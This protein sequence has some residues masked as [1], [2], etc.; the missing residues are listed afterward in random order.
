MEV[1]QMRK[2]ERFIQEE[3]RVLKEELAHMF[4]RLIVLHYKYYKNNEADTFEQ[5]CNS[6]NSVII[7]TDQEQIEIYHKVDSIIEKEN[8]LFFAHYEL[9]KTIYLVDVSGKDEY[10]VKSSNASRKN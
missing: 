5:Y 9:N 6:F 3:N 4:A 7:L 1:I 2:R 10:D 8:N